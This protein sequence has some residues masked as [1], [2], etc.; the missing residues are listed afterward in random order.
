MAGIIQCAHCGAEFLATKKQWKTHNAKPGSRQYCSGICQRAGFALFLPRKPLKHQGVC[1][2]CGIGFRSRY[3]K[4]FCGMKCYIASPQFGEMIRQNSAEIRERALQRAVI[5]PGA[6]VDGL[7]VKI[8]CLQCHADIVIKPSSPRKYCS[9]QCYRLY[10]AQRFDR[11]IAN[12]QDIALPQ[13]FDE[14]LSQEELPC[15][16]DGCSWVGQ[17]LGNHVNFAHGITADEFKRAAGFNIKTGLITPD[18]A[19][20]MSGRPHLHIPGVTFGGVQPHG[21]HG[22]CNYKSLEGAEHYAKA[23]ALLKETTVPPPRPCQ[24]CGRSFT[25]QPIGWSAKFCTLECRAAHYKQKNTVKQ[26]SMKC[27][28]CGNEFLGNKQQKLRWDREQE[29]TCS[30]SCK[31]SHY[32]S[33]RLT[34]NR[35]PA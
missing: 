35:K 27:V 22:P 12:P 1:L 3:P 16:I 32:W 7:L 21:Y 14:F 30:T 11:W 8:K 23:M 18:V 4:L 24:K 29:V 31:G 9:K 20:K 5:P 28:H 26:F 19:E 17:Q 13:A 2:N 15:L 33:R 34:G 6:E 25:P 10:M